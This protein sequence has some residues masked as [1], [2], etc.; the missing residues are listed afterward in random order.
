MMKVVPHRD[1]S[2]T[3][4]HPTNILY[5]LQGYTVNFGA[6]STPVHWILQ[7]PQTMEVF[8]WFFIIIIIPIQKDLIL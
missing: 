2:V 8:L 5:P 3:T 6:A 1:G 4:D 7:E